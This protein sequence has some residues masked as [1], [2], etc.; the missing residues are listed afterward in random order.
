M[1]CAVSCLS[2]SSKRFATSG[3]SNSSAVCTVSGYR[4]PFPRPGGVETARQLPSHSMPSAPNKHLGRAAAR[5]EALV[6]VERATGA[7]AGEWGHPDAEHL[8]L[9]GSAAHVAAMPRGDWESMGHDAPARACR[10][11]WGYC[12]EALLAHTDPQ[13]RVAAEEA[14]RLIVGTGRTAT[15]REPVIASPEGTEVAKVFTGWPRCSTY[16][17]DQFSAF[18]EM[19]Q[20]RCINHL[21]LD[22]T[23]IFRD[24]LGG[25]ES[26]AFAWVLGEP[27]QQE[28]R[29]VKAIMVKDPSLRE[30][31][32]PY[33]EALKLVRKYAR[34]NPEWAAAR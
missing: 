1:A 8:V 18:E 11:H 21:V 5:Y 26:T 24:M 25:K 34:Q 19:V 15:E 28:M 23:E 17:C 20:L 4:R 32:S 3:V 12:R 2:N 6:K 14:D 10:E 27:G 13:V 9:A 16:S 22:A 30:S 7:N 29:R 33:H 31:Y